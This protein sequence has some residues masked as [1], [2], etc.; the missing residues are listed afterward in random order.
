MVIGSGV[1]DNIDTTVDQLSDQGAVSSDAQ[2]LQ[3]RATTLYANVN[4]DGIDVSL[5][6]SGQQG[7]TFGIP[8]NLKEGLTI[9][10]LEVIQQNSVGII[11]KNRTTGEVFQIV[12]AD[13][14]NQDTTGNIA[15]NTHPEYAVGQQ[16]DGQ[17]VYTAVM[18]GDWMKKIV[19]AVTTGLSQASDISGDI[20]TFLIGNGKSL[21]PS[22]LSSSVQSIIQNPLSAVTAGPGI[23]ASIASLPSQFNVDSI[24]NIGAS[25]VVATLVDLLNMLGVDT[26]DFNTVYQAQIK[27]IND[28]ITDMNAFGDKLMNEGVKESLLMPA[29]I[30]T[31]SA[32]N[33]IISVL[34]DENLSTANGI[35][36]MVNSYLTGWTEGI[37]NALDAVFTG[38][39]TIIAP[40]ANDPMH[41][42]DGKTPQEVLNAAIASADGAGGLVAQFAQ[43]IIEFFLNLA[44]Q[45][46]TE[47]I[48]PVIEKISSF[49]TNGL[50]Q[51]ISKAIDGAV[52]G[53]SQV[54]AV[55]VE[56]NDPSYVSQANGQDA[57][58]GQF[59]GET[60]DT[61]SKLFNQVQKS[62]T[63]IAYQNVDKTQLKALI[64]KGAPVVQRF[65]KT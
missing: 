4:S 29:E 50:G 2:N 34:S 55:P 43:P 5:V 21:L 52:G 3:K 47:A 49:A 36:N 45:A 25:G 42:F 30:K 46:N 58:P 61:I 64:A 63:T 57:A 51:A 23:L 22:S 32:G 7:A 53:M 44:S 11:V 59:I 65:H 40:D 20:G 62:S 6:G 1:I 14:G 26:T 28:S 48:Q 54:V 35:T 38:N 10:G 18:N 39:Q 33:D 56:Y 24:K 19:E 37:G 13:Y 27:Q 31:D 41:K 16:I 9:G 17:A 12:N 15:N 60:F 8:K